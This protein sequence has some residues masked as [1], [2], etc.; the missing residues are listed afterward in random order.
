[1]AYLIDTDWAVDY[2]KGV[3]EKVSFLQSAEDLY[4]TSI[5]IGEL[6]EG[7]EGSEK[8]EDRIRGLENFLT[9]IT[10]VSFTEEMA[11]TFG[12][13]R[14]DLR[15]KGKLPGDID[16]MIAATALHLDLEVLTDNK[17]HFEHIPSIELYC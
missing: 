11:Y 4:I 2:L 9:N 10:V 8:K 16:L 6:M 15:K 1:M 3:N 7:I 13:I 5:S 12:K 14:N 17:K